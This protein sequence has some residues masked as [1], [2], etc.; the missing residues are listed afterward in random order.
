MNNRFLPFK[1]IET[2]AIFLLDDDLVMNRQEITTAF[3]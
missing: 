1:L 2:E 3:R